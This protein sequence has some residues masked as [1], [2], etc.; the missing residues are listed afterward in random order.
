MGFNTENFTKVVA[1]AKQNKGRVATAAYRGLSVGALAYLFATFAQV[2]DVE[3]LRE[4]M[5]KL[6]TARTDQIEAVD[7][8]LDSLEKNQAFISGRLGFPML[9]SPQAVNMNTNKP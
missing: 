9:A 4:R 2:K 5:N 1:T 6:S 7:K 8:R 3:R